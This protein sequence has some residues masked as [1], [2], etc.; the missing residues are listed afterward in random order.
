MKLTPAQ[1]DLLAQAAVIL[2]RAIRHEERLL[3]AAGYERDDALQ[4]LLLVFAQRLQG[5]NPYDPALAQLSSYLYL[6]THSVLLNRVARRQR[7]RAGWAQVAAE[8]RHRHA[9]LDVEALARVS[10]EAAWTAPEVGPVAEGEQVAL[11]AAEVEAVPVARA[12]R[13]SGG[14]SRASAPPQGLLFGLAAGTGA[15]PSGFP[16]GA[17]KRKGPLPLA[18]KTRAGR[19]S[20]SRPAGSR[21]KEP[22]P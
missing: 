10:A 19:F 14:A 1:S 6:L 22:K 3:V 8:E 11:I 9:E 17:R 2:P 12:R 5:E 15:E 20:D 4:E 7:R 16:G 13:P 18:E 21:R